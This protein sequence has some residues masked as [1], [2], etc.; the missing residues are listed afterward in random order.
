MTIGVSLSGATG[1]S[2]GQGLAGPKGSLGKELGGDGREGRRSCDQT[3]GI[4]LAKTILDAERTRIAG[5]GVRE[6]VDKK[7]T[8][9][10]SVR[11]ECL[12]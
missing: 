12:F 11:F 7:I 8:D 5:W 9:P 3:A 2:R 6:V 4:Q 1:G 10:Y